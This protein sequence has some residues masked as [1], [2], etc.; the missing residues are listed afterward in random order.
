MKK[1]RHTKP[2]QE[3]AFL[4][5]SPKPSQRYFFKHEPRNI[6]NSENYRKTKPGGR[7]GV[8]EGELSFRT[9]VSEG[10]RVE[11]SKGWVRG[12]Q[13]RHY[14]DETQ[15][16][17][18]GAEKGAV[19][20]SVPK[21]GTRGLGKREQEPG[22]EEPGGCFPEGSRREWGRGRVLTSIIFSFFFCSAFLL[23]PA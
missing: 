22:T 16:A 19:G 11:R 14:S 9:G 15:R 7:Y 18:P 1:I 3:S 6:F 13:Q 21:E 2:C 20:N 17:L 4:R 10:R 12:R 8:R 23:P 5:I